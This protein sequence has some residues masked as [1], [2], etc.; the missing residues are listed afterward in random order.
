MDYSGDV[1]SVEDEIVVLGDG[2]GD[3]DNGRLLKGIGA[4]QAAWDLACDGDERDAI[5]EGVS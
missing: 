2:A 1:V 3:V 5:V 4:D